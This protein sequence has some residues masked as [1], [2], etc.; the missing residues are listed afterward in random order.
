MYQ[1]RTEQIEFVIQSDK[2]THQVVLHLAV[3][4]FIVPTV[5]VMVVAIDQEI[6]EETFLVSEEELFERH[7]VLRHFLH[8]CLAKGLL[9]DDELDLLLQ[10]KL[11]G[12]R[13]E[14]LGGSEGISANAFR[15]RAKRLLGKLRRLAQR[16]P[17]VVEPDGEG[18]S[19]MGTTQKKLQNL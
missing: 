9:A 8:R 16:P 13:G 15:Q 2:L 10:F 12:D 6:S 3:H 1:I 7:A 5:A 17:S 14:D 11:D 4:L 19:P 18:S